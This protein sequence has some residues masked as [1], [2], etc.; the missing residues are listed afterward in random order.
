MNGTRAKGALQFLEK[1][2]YLFAG[3]K[4][5]AK[6]KNWLAYKYIY[7]SLRYQGRIQRKKFQLCQR[8]RHQKLQS[9]TF[10]RLPIPNVT[11]TP[12]S[13]A[14]SEKWWV[15]LICKSGTPSGPGKRGLM[16]SANAPAIP[17]DELVI[18]FSLSATSHD[19]Y[20]IH[21]DYC[22]H[23]KGELTPTEFDD[24]PD[25]DKVAL[26]REVIESFEYRFLREPVAGSSTQ[27][28]GAEIDSIIAEFA[29]GKRRV[30]FLSLEPKAYPAAAYDALIAGFQI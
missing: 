10:S 5:T 2:K 9:G 29:A 20:V 14:T 4:K 8:H 30:L 15:K 25:E 18:V 11:L 19:E 23:P 27:T 13:D 1:T 24:L 17:N 26:A 3:H 16:L 6:R 28:D 12:D 7:V 21:G 22:I